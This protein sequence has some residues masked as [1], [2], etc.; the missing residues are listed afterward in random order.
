MG[1]Q[2]YLSLIVLGCAS[3]TLFLGQLL[4]ASP[5]MTEVLVAD[6][7]FKPFSRTQQLRNISHCIGGQLFSRNRD[8]IRGRKRR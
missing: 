6:R 4:S 1:W 7:I 3:A 8:E 5:A 2:D